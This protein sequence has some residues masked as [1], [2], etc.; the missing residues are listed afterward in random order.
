MRPLRIVGAALALGALLPAVGAAQ[1]LQATLDARREALPGGKHAWQETWLVPEEGAAAPE[2]SQATR[3]AG[4]V[5][6]YQDARKERLELRAASGDGLAEPVVV[7]FDGEQHWLVTRVGA[8]PLAQSAR[9]SDPWLALVLSGPPGETPAHRV[10]PADAGEIAAVVLRAT[11]PTD[12]EASSAFA[13]KLP[14]AGSGLMRSGLAAFSPANDPGV[15]AAAGARGVDQVRTPSGTV[16]VTPDPAAV[17]WME[18]QGVTPMALERFRLEARL[19]P[20]DA[21]PA[22]AES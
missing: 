4:R 20:Y 13:L 3:F 16:S 5:T 14:Q 17:Q 10:V 7:V 6:A 11:E 2:A 12:F 19:A 22:E 8:T 1:G 18:G 9:A 21:L 15:T